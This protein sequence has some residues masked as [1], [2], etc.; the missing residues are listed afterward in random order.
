MFGEL[1]FDSELCLF[2]NTTRNICRISEIIYYSDSD[3][4]KKTGDYIKVDGIDTISFVPKSKLDICSKFEDK[5]YRTQIKIGKFVSKFFRK[6]S[7]QRFSISSVD[8]EVFVNL[9]KSYFD[10][11]L[12]K[13]KVISGEEILQYY[14]EDNYLLH[15]GYRYGTL[16]N[17]CMRYKEKNEFMRIYAANP[18]KV[19]ML[20]NLD[21]S[22][23]LKTRAL[24]WEDAEDNNGNKYKIMDRIYSVY[25]HEVESFKKWAKQNG[26]IFKYEQSAK[27]EIFFNTGESIK[28][29]YLK[30]KLDSWKL[31]KYPY[32]DTFKYLSYS[33]GILSNNPANKYDFVLIQ[34]D[35]QLE[36]EE[37]TD[38]DNE[39][40]TIDIEW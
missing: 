33:D 18:N 8:I 20:I 39:V 5:K 29:L 12:S 34:N 21:S 36:R 1:N 30:I 9:F 19:K 10:S 4:I 15:N 16:W 2:I 7:I 22:G 37:E 17:S 13:F 28:D 11:D 38:E 25:D 31:K 24:L 40:D 6:E 27:N 14:L 26:Y 35:G 32:I 23:K 3:I